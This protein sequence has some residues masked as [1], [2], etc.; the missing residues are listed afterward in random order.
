MIN[1]I[2]DVIDSIRFP[3][4]VSNV[5]TLHFKNLN[6]KNKI[7][8]KVLTAYVKNKNRDDEYMVYTIKLV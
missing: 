4:N 7:L 1:N 5:T 2:L 8:C 3:D 6:F